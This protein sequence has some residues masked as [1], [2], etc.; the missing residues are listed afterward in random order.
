[1]LNSSLDE[2]KLIGCAIALMYATM[3]ASKMHN[4]RSM[5]LSPRLG[6]RKGISRPVSLKVWLDDA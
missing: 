5:S 3:S 1:M 4:R 2:S 6:A